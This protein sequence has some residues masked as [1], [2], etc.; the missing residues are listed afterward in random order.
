MFNCED[1]V[2]HHSCVIYCSFFSCGAHYIRETIR[3]FEI[4]GKNIVL[5]EI[6]AENI[7]G[8]LH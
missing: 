6:K 2:Q 8:M 1:N 3:N 7:I 5:G 4:E